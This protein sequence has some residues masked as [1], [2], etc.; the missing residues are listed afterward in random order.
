MHE[1]LDREN[2]ENGLRWL[3]ARSD[4][5]TANYLLDAI[6]SDAK[7]DRYMRRYWPQ[8]FDDEAYAAVYKEAGEIES[9]VN[10]FS[11]IPGT[12]RYQVV[13]Q[14]LQQAGRPKRVLDFGCSRAYHAIHLHNALGSQFTCVDI[15]QVS[16]DQANEMIKKAARYP[17][18]MKAL[19]AADC[20]QFAGQNFDAVMCLET[21]EHVPNVG[22]LLEQFE[23]CVKPDGW[24]IVTLP[25]GP[26]EYTMWVEHPERNREH[27]REIGLQDCYELWSHKPGFYLTLFASG[28]NKYA[29]MTEGNIVVM[30][31]SDGKPCGQV[32]M[33]RK[34]LGALACNG[35]EL[36][37]KDGVLT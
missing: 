14:A 5:E 1:L 16:I 22:A 25:H 18:G 35:P 23:R 13:L 10:V 24:I 27:L 32:N 28:V 6:G 2:P 31:Q 9:K 20:E 30:Y 3:L 36:P 11:A 26:V 12:H 4:V 19:V 15:D 17:A 37:D 8:F 29:G 33:Q 34:I 21:L 7:Y